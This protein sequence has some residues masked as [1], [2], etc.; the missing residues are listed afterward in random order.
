MQLLLGFAS[1]ERALV[2]KCTRLERLLYDSSASNFVEA[3]L[4]CM[5]QI[6][7][8]F[9]RGSM[10]LAEVEDLAEARLVEEMKHPNIV[11]TFDHGTRVKHFSG[12]VS[13][14]RF[15]GSNS[16]SQSGRPDPASSGFVLETWLLLEYCNKGSLQVFILP[17]DNNRPDKY[18]WLQ[19][20]V[21]CSGA[22]WTLGCPSEVICEFALRDFSKLYE[23]ELQ[24]GLGSQIFFD[25]SVELV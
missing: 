22:L 9:K 17:A 16:R 8:T 3:N 24:V 13:A 25:R 6:L 1:L 5:L 12:H 4:Q 20:S 23:S 18:I 15:S 2:S 7:E 19:T 21:R 11:R 14:E 10:D